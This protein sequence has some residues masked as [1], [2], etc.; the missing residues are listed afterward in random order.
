ME[1]NHKRDNDVCIAKTPL[2]V[3]YRGP[4]VHRRGK[5]HSFRPTHETQA[6]IE[7][8][9]YRNKQQRSK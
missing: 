4:R 5:C 7:Q 3:F 1:E 6:K 2:S 8:Q 9:R